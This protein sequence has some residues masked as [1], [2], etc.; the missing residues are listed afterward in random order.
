MKVFHSAAC[1]NTKHVRYFHNMCRDTPAHFIWIQQKMLLCIRVDQSCT[2][3]LIFFLIL[4]K[5]LLRLHKW[6]EIHL[7]GY[8]TMP[9]S[10]H[11][12]YSESE[13]RNGT[14]NNNKKNPYQWKCFESILS[15]LDAVA[16]G[17]TEG[18]SLLVPPTHRRWKERSYLCEPIEIT[19]SQ[20]THK[21]D[22]DLKGWGPDEHIFLAVPFL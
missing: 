11:W 22:E 21:Q 18:S 2:T 15:L 4:N 8:F 5:N 1:L 14:D 19:S 3:R 16:T 10:L 6:K 13:A 7:P 9:S 20:S 12:H 17:C